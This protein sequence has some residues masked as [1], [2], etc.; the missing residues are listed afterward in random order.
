ML[1]L[2]I[3]GPKEERKRFLDHFRVQ[4][5][6]QLL[7]PDGDYELKEDAAT[8]VQF[9][10]QH[11]VLKP[12]LRKSFWVELVTEDQEKLRIHLLDGNVINMGNG[13]TIIYGKNYDIFSP[14][15]THCSSKTVDYKKEG[16]MLL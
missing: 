11:Q 8:V 9:E 5:Y 4:P 14:K 13:N 16:L 1:N 2:S 12:S 15:K 3:A 7:S 6:Y 10:F